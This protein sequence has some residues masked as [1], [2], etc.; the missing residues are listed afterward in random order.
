[1]TQT[2]EYAKARKRAEAKYGFFVHTAV[3]AAV[4]LLLVVINLVTS[5]RVIWFIWPM[6]GWGFAVA[7]HGVGVFMVADK[8]AI[9]DA[10]TER[11]L[12]NSS[13]SARNDW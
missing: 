10:L 12:R 11:E 3:Y 8:N 5:P 13:Q 2:D 6:I 4:M 9:V 1:M 7:L